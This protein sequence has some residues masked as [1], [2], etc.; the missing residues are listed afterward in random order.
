MASVWITTRTTRSGDKR[1]RVEFRIGGPTIYGGSFKT[2]REAQIRKAWIAGELAARRVPELRFAAA[3]T[4]ETLRT[5]AARWRESRVDV[6]SGTNTTYAVNLNRILPLLGDRPV[7][8]L[9]VTDVAA[10]VAT[11]HKAGLARES[12][13]KTRSTLA[14][15][16]DFGGIEPNPARDT[17][18]VKLPREEPEEPNPPTADHI[19]RVYRL[20]A[21]Q[22]RLPVLWLDWSGARVASV[23][24]LVVGDYDEQRRRVRARAATTKTRRPLWI[25]L[26]PVLAN[27]IERTLPPRDDRDLAAPLFPG[28]NSD[29]LRTAIAKAC[30]ATGTPLWSPHDLKHRRISLLHARGWSWAKI[31]EFTGNRSLKVTATRTRTCSWTRPNSTTPTCCCDPD[32]GCGA[33]GPR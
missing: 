28:T 2:K 6:A 31:G 5:L 4:A 3:P 25:E 15:V 18:T 20:L 33:S 29:A 26:H 17:K 7:D 21:S 22:H 11:L 12:I 1:H 10:L 23:D 27:A 19:E 16:L 13:R 8:E 24:K 32:L 30:R 14:Q 9:D